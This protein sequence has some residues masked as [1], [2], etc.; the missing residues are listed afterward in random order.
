MSKIWRKSFIELVIS[1]IRFQYS[2]YIAIVTEFSAGGK[3]HNIDFPAKIYRYNS[4]KA[5]KLSYYEHNKKHRLDKPAKIW[6]YE[7][8]M[9]Q[10]LRFYR[11]DKLHRSQY[12]TLKQCL[13]RTDITNAANVV[14]DTRGNILTK[15]YAYKG[16]PIMANHKAYVPCYVSFHDNGKLRKIIYNFTKAK[17]VPPNWN[18]TEIEYYKSGIIKELKYKVNYVYRNFNGEEGCIPA[19]RSYYSSGML[20]KETYKYRNKTHRLPKFGPAKT[21]YYENGNVELEVYKIKGKM[22]NPSGSC[23][24]AYDEKGNKIR[25]WNLNNNGILITTHYYPSSPRG[26]ECNITYKTIENIKIE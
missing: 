6:Y 17:D 10:E 20:K 11:Y 26:T 25:E 4:G 14:Y 18:S 23:M 19:Y 12:P 2:N 15:E 16:H 13:S 22:R 7:D 9:L 8:G 1:H 24:I 21:K 3:F 5:R